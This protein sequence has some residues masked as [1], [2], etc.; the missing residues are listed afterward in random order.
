MLQQPSAEPFFTNDA[1][2]FI[3]IVGVMVTVVVAPIMIF[4][5][6][7]SQQSSVGA[8]VDLKKTT[9]ASVN[10][11][12]ERLNAQQAQCSQ[13]ATLLATTREDVIRMREASITMTER[14]AKTETNLES[15]EKTLDGQQREIMAAITESGRAQ[16]QAT[17]DLE[18]QI[19]VLNERANL[20]E[21]LKKLGDQLVQ[22][23]RDRGEVQ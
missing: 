22:A 11:L 3:K 2:G 18:K 14:I 9:E 23:I 7:W 19:V 4:L 21:G 15:I 8:V 17:H 10:G 13:T 5:W 1:I 12:G 16:M 6:R 20:V